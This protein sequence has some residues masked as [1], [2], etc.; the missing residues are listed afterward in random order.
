MGQFFRRLL[1]KKNR[2]IALVAV[3]RKLAVIASH[4]LKNNE[5]YRYALP[6]S[7]GQELA[8]LRSQATGQKRKTGPS[9]EAAEKRRVGTR[10]RTVP[11]LATVY[12]R[13]GVP[14]LRAPE[15]PPPG[16]K[17][18]IEEPSRSR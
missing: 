16:E 18:M 14:L 8:H 1:K 5:P 6:D 2:N 12:Q 17:R 3:A 4:M 13:E 15:S 7:T 10:S 9:Q 11:S